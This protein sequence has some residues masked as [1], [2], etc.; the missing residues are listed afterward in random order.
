LVH[1]LV[2]YLVHRCTA[3]LA[4]RLELDLNSFPIDVVGENVIRLRSASRLGSWQ[5]NSFGIVV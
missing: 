4:D 1:Y 2:H 3:F 5:V